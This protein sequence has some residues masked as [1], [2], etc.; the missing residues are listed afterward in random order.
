MTKSSLVEKNFY[1][2]F[3]VD[4][5]LTNNAIDKFFKLALKTGVQIFH[6]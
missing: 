1:L 3:K 4:F 6:E 2:M 5:A